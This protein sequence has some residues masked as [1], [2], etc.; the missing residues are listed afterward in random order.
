MDKSQMTEYI[1]INF[2]LNETD[3]LMGNGEGMWL[4]VDPTTKA[5]YDADASGGHYV[6]I[7]DND[8][9]YFPGLNH[10]ECIPFEM[11]GVYRPVADFPGLLSKLTRL[12]P[13]GK[14]IIIRAIAS[15]KGA[16]HMTDSSDQSCEGTTCCDCQFC[17]DKYS[18][19]TP[20]DLLYMD[21]KDPLIKHFY[22]CCGDCE[23]YEKDIT[24]LGIQECEHFEE[25]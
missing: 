23:L 15:R 2:P 6:G 1:K 8:S 17:G 11:R 25:L 14:A 9:V 20:N 3:Y 21:P 22:C 7:L 13:E 12:T 19:P 10:G 24:G 18:F 4:K 5:A 16:G